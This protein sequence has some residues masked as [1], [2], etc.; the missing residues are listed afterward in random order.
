MD[1]KPDKPFL[2][3]EYC[4]AM[5][6]GPG[7]LEDYFQ[8]IY[9]YDVLCGGF[10]WEWC[11]H[12]VYQGQAAN[13]KEKYLYGGAFGEEVHDGNFCMDGLVYPDRTP[14]TGLLEY[15]NV[16][17]PA[18]VMSF[19]QKTGE[20]CLENYMNYVDLKDYIYLVYEVN[21]DGKLLEKKPLTLQD[22]VL[23]HQRGSIL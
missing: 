6:N 17:R 2:L 8:M 4:H 22:S 23:P 13:G 9:Q 14:H 10:V 18:R 16:Y 3:I 11:D 15:Q 7:D 19:C 5:G 20:L 21:C 1:K 12:A